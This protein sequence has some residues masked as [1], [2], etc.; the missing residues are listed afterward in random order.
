[1]NDEYASLMKHDTCNL[2]ELPENR[3][4]IDS[5]W[6]LKT[7][8]NADGSIDRYKARLV[9][10][11]FTQEPGIELEETFSPVARLTSIG[12]LLAIVNQLN[13]DLHQMDVSTAFLNGDLREEI[14]MRQPEGYIQGNNPNLVCKLN[15]VSTD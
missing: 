10:R 11:G 3:N 7:K 4:V 14:Y 15:K 5:K 2:V 8:Y 6:V 12:T 1:M 13:L 9:A